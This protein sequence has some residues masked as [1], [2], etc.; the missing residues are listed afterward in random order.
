MP[1]STADVNWSVDAHGP[2]RGKKGEKRKKGK[3]D[4]IGGGGGKKQQQHKQ[5]QTMRL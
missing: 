4:E 5:R 3:R 2:G 1:S